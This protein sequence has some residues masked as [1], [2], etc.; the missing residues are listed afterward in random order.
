MNRQLFPHIAMI[1]GILLALVL[2]L[3]LAM[4]EHTVPLIDLRGPRNVVGPL[5]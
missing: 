5:G 1:G 2:D 3:S 4:I